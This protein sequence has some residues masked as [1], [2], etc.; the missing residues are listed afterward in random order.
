MTNVISDIT[1]FTPV[2]GSISNQAKLVTYRAYAPVHLNVRH[3][4]KSEKVKFFA[5]TKFEIRANKQLNYLTN[6]ANCELYTNK[7]N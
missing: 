1:Q 4:V 2:I 5:E 7:D 3:R 6:Y